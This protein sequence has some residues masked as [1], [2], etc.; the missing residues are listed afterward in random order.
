MYKGDSHV[1]SCFSTD[2]NEK[3]ENIF[4]RA[5]ELG[6]NEITIT[7]HM[8]YADREEDDYFVFNIND[9][10]K[11]LNAYKQKYKDRL[12]IKIGMELGLQ[13]QL[14]KRFE[15]ILK[16]DVYDFLI[17]SSHAVDGID[18]GFSELYRRF[19][20]KDELHKRYFETILENLEVY[21]GINTYGHLDYIIRYGGAFF[22]DH[23]ELNLELHKELIDKI[24]TKLIE[25]K[26][27]LEINTSGIRYK[28][29]DFHPRRE[30]LAR[31]RELGGEIITLGS[32]AHK[33]SDIAKD[34]DTAREHLKSL[35]FTHFCTFTKKK[36]EFHEL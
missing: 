12:N 25:K 7:D 9:Y 35:G 34:F 15:P 3:L 20:N 8:D 16:S 31:Y 10:L 30:I 17:G 21:D 11:T 5:I 33:A 1:H 19:K 14:Y 13:P 24:L 4:E 28:V 22:P 2:S 36:P 32:D 6:L 18:A 26:I 29:G 27:G 23:K